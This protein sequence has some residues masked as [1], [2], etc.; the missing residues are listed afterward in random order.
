MCVERFRA[1]ISG[2][3]Q[4]KTLWLVLQ[5]GVQLST[6]CECQLQVKDH[7]LCLTALR[8]LS[9][10]LLLHCCWLDTHSRH[11][12]LKLDLLHR[13]SARRGSGKAGSAA[14]ELSRAGAASPA[15][16]RQGWASNSLPVP[17]Q[18][19]TAWNGLAASAAWTS[20]S[21]TC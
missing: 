8:H 1:G 3:F 13:L 19:G 15:P 2:F 21:P 17:R 6:S 12:L 4:K 7:F 5:I 18:D 20:F 10:P 16:S 14:A 9:I 11:Q